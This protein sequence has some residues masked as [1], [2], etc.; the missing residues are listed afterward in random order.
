M[1]KHYSIGESQLLFTA[2][3]LIEFLNECYGS[4]KMNIVY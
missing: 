1:S 4:V 2:T 3:V